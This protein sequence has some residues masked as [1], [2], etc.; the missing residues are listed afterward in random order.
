MPKDFQMIDKFS[1]DKFSN[2]RFKF[3]FWHCSDIIIWSIYLFRLQ[4]W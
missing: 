4:H 3:Y 1:N 2:D